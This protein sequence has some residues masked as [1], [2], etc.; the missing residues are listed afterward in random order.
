MARSPAEQHMEAA[1]RTYFEQVTTGDVDG[2]LELFADDAQL[3]NP[4][5]G[6]EGS[7][8]KLPCV[9]STRTWC[10]ASSITKPVPPTS[11]S[12]ATSSWHPS[13]SREK[14]EMGSQL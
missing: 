4:M 14:P 3:I 10:R 5:T 11:S 13:T 7:E 2:I 6:E 12:K 9:P 8:A 1:A